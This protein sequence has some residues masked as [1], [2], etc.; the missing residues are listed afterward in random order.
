[1]EHKLLLIT[2]LGASFALSPLARAAQTDANGPK[3]R[4]D[5]DK[6]AQVDAQTSVLRFSINHYIVENASLISPAEINE[7]VAPYIGKD[8]DFS[9]IQRALEA[10]E[11]AYT[12]RGFSAVRVLLPEQELE[13]GTVHFRVIES[14]FGKV[15]VKDNQFVSTDNAL[16]ALPSVRRGNAPRS[17]QIARE[18]KFANQNPARQLNVVLKAGERDEEVDANVIVTDSRPSTWGFTA[19]N[20]GT[21]EI[22]TTRLGV[23]YRHANVFDKDHLVSLQYLMSPQHPNRLTVLGGSYKIPFY[24]SGDSLEFFGGYSNVNSVIGGTSNF[25]GGGLLFS[26]RYNH[27]LQRIAMFDTSLSLGL[28]WRD[29]R[30]I[31]LTNPPPTVLYNEIVVTPLS[32]MYA[33]QGK[34]T[35]S[36]LDLNVSFSANLPGMNKGHAS[37]F[38]AYDRLNFTRPVAN[39]RLVRY[40]VKYSQ[41]VGNDWQFRAALNGQWSRDTLIQGEQIRLGGVDAV[42]GFSEGS[43]GGESGNRWNLEWYTPDFGKGDAK[44]RALA[45]FDGGEVSSANGSRSSISSAGFGL[46]A[47]YI[48]QYT[49]RM[50]AGR[51]INAGND[52]TQRVGDWRI[53]LGLSASF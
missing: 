2:L 43:E 45:F 33:A 37:D 48:E 27:P 52:P 5:A 9:D 34:F 53:H 14:R 50:N 21:P 23:F 1:M 11:N 51:I 10:I 41:S 13:N 17:K 7:A 6:A 16:N 36:D 3:M 46:Q 38:A 39:Y 40:G 29:F 30:R 24:Q 15:T 31:E 49:L 26:A 32:I 22:G 4:L 12:A 35:K 18:L 44:T 28:D 25:Q 8:K 42:R 47:A 19:D 20:T